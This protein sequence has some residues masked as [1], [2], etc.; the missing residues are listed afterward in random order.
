MKPT[1]D[2]PVTLEFKGNETRVFIGG[3]FYGKF[4]TPIS[5]DDVRSVLWPK[6][7]TIAMGFAYMAAFEKDRSITL[8]IFLERY[9]P[10]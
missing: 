4:P 7:P 3:A 1:V 9:R 6:A 10:Q 8:D 2:G 5:P